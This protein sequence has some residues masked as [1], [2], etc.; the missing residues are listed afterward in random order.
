MTIKEIY[1][2]RH[3]YR[4]N[5][6]PPPHPPNPTGVPSDPP[7][8]P[9][10]V[11]QAKQLA[12]YLTSLPTKDQ[13]QFILTSPF[14]RCVQ[15]AEPIAQLLDLKIHLDR[16]VGEWFKKGRKIVP[17]PADYTDLTKFFPQVLDKEDV[18]PRDRLGVIPNL[19]GETG[20]EIYT[21]ATQFWHHFIPTF[22]KEYP[23]VE[24]ILIVTHAATKIALGS[25][26][27]KLGS[28]TSTIDGE[29]TMLRAGACSL[30]KYVRI[31]ASNDFDWKIIMNGNCEFLTKGEEMNWD[32]TTG[33]EA[34]SAEDIARRKKEA[35]Q[36]GSESGGATGKETVTGSDGEAPVT[37]IA[38][39][40]DE[41]NNEDGFETF[42][43]TVDLPNVP[44][45]LDDDDSTIDR[46]KTRKT[47]RFKNNILKP[48]ARLQMTSLGDKSP[49]VKI[50]NNTSN[51]TVR[52]P[53][54]TPTTS[55]TE[56]NSH[57][58]KHS[59]IIDASTLINGQIFETN[60]HE[61][62]GSELIF[63]DYGELIGQV[64][65]HL[66]C[67]DKVKFIPKKSHNEGKPVDYVDFED[68]FAEES[69]VKLEGNVKSK[70]SPFLRNA[71][72]VAK[73]KEYS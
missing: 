27:L 72:K 69:S 5:W 57:K 10:G 21:R 12:A 38:T 32:F 51:A 9:H 46:T 70:P 18:W 63:D 41:T 49:L 1:I 68:G 8:A 34:G 31:S 48:S 62:T 30:S 65:E 45:N 55:T 15:T 16:G 17:E 25:V 59:S 60:W 6:L 2:A 58:S 47:P 40:A 67:N 42:Y 11:D 37:E 14:Y 28:V 4:M 52:D 53:S 66:T 44:K 35:E 23:D 13:P 29:K 71:I 7:L 36:K 3:G 19:E 61:L 54:H 73:R 43:I 64:K 39:G 56:G 26:L 22:E 50:S 20:E 24:N 33:V